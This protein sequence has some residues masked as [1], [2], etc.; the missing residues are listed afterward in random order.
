MPQTKKL[1]RFSTSGVVM[2][3]RWLN[4]ALIN[5]NEAMQYVALDD[6]AAARKMAVF[7]RNQV[8]ELANQPY[9]GRKGRIFG[10]RELVIRKYP[11]ILPY[12][13]LDGELLI[14]RVF[15]TSQELPDEW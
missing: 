10:T 7:I 9:S 4:K 13:V 3:I 12:Q 1:T 15:H 8:K 14:L 5:L 2:K 6:P 11:F